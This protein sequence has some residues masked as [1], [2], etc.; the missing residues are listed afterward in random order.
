MTELFL[1]LA[2]IHPSFSPMFFTEKQEFTARLVPLPAHQ[3]FK[4]IKTWSTYPVKD[5][6]PKTNVSTIR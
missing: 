4:M 6:L 1:Q 2:F 3:S 5:V